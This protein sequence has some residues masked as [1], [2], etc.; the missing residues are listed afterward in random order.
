MS[1]LEHHS[2]RTVTDKVLPAELEAAHSLHGSK[3]DGN[4]STQSGLT[5]DLLVHNH[6]HVIHL[7]CKMY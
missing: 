4:C 1:P 6:V 2:E 5:G 7:R 3:K